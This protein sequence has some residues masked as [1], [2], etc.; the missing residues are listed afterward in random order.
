MQ[1]RLLAQI[2]PYLVATA[3]LA[4]IVYAY[5]RLLH[6]NAT[7]VAMTFTIGILIISAY[8]GLRVSIYMSVAAALCFNFFFLPPFLTFTVSDRQNWVALIAFLSTGIIA[9][10]LSDRARTETRMSN[11]RRREAERMYEFSQ[12]LLVAPNVVELVAAIPGK[13]MNVFALRNVALFLQSR[14]QTYR[15]EQTFFAD[16]RELRLAAGCGRTGPGCFG[17]SECQGQYLQQYHGR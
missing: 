1:K 13:L 12:Q 3:M 9:S 16:D 15:S 5:Y 14:N 17:R 4:L 7:T 10:N 2:I 11:R 6:V 8:W